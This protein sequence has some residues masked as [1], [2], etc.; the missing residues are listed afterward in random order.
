VTRGITLGLFAALAVISFA[1]LTGNRYLS[2]S[3]AAYNRYDLTAAVRDARRA[4]DWAP[5]ST[6]ALQ[7]EADAVAVD[8]SLAEARRLY[9]RALA[10][11]S[12]NWALWFGLALASEGE[13]RRRNL[14]RAAALN[15]LQTEIRQLREQVGVRNGTP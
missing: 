6:D 3:A 5:W 14:E 15:P 9:R 7:A 10:K 8:G 1:T 13:A 12:R 4:R 2:Q 11:D